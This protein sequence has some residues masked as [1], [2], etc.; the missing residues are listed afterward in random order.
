MNGSG[1]QGFRYNAAGTAEK[2]IPTALYI[3]HV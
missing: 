3:P 1:K 2:P